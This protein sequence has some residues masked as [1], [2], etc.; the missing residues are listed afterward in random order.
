MHSPT[1]VKF[2]SS[3]GPI[4]VTQPK[5]RQD[6]FT[7]S[8]EVNCQDTLAPP[9]VSISALDTHTD[10]NI[11]YCQ[12]ISDANSDNDDNLF[13]RDE[14]E[15]SKLISPKGIVQNYTL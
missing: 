1:P 6:I 8:L 5:H 11:K 2:S 4:I 14:T 7:R 9:T 3:D 12:T 15:S 13:E 10:G